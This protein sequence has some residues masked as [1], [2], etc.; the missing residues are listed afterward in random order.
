[1]GLL[2]HSY[3]APFLKP[4]QPGPALLQRLSGAPGWALLAA[5]VTAALAAAVVRQLHI[6]HGDG[7]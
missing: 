3:L 2:A 1:M 5:V 4:A 7:L 6:S